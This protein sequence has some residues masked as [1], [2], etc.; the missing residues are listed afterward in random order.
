MQHGSDPLHECT[1]EALC[2]SILLRGVRSCGLMDDAVAFG[3]VHEGSIEVLTAS[4][5]AHQLDLLPCLNLQHL[6]NL[7]DCCCD[8]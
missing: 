6:E 7:L 4:V 1:V 8:V 3:E 5:C 2:S